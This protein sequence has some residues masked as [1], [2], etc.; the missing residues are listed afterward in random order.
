MCF[1]SPRISEIA[2]CAA[3]MAMVSIPCS[4]QLIF[5]AIAS[6]FRGSL[7]RYDVLPRTV[8]RSVDAT[9]RACEECAAV[10]LPVIIRRFLAAIV[11]ALAPQVPFNERPDILQ[12]PS[13]HCLQHIPLEPKLHFAFLHSPVP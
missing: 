10:P 3:A 8:L 11:S 12:G 2:I 13:M 4:L 6:N 9:C 7:I 1:S 5:L